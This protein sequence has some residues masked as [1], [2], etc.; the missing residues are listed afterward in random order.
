MVLTLV[1]WPDG[2]EELSV[3]ATGK[4][5]AQYAMTKVQV[6]SLRIPFWMVLERLWRSI[7]RVDPGPGRYTLSGFEVDL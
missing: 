6:E 1:K 2:P 3:W 4:R 5:T 7:E